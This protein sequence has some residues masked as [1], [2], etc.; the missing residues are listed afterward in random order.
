[1]TI[2]APDGAFT[3]GGGEWNFGQSVSQEVAQA[4]FMLPV[5]TPDNLLTVL[6][7]VLE[8]LPLEALRAFQP[9]FGL[10][11]DLFTN[12][13]GAVQA[14]I[15]NLIT[16]PLMATIEMLGQWLTTILQT[17][18]PWIDWAGIPDDV[19]ELLAW[20]G[21]VLHSIPFFGDFLTGAETFVEALIRNLVHW[22]THPGEI[23]DAIVAALQQLFSH[24]G[25][26]INTVISS[27]VYWLTHPGDLLTGIINAVKGALA[28]GGA[29]VQN[30][31]DTVVYWL[32]HPGDLFNAL[33]TAVQNFFTLGGDLVGTIINTLVHWM[34][35]AGAFL[36][37]LVNAVISWLKTVGIDLTGPLSF[38]QIIVDNVARFFGQTGETL[39]KWASGLV[40]A[41]NLP[42]L[43]QGLFG[44][45][46]SIFPVSM[47][48]QQE[49]VNLLNMGIFQSASTLENA[50]GWSFDSSKN[51][52]GNTGGSAKLD[53]AYQA[54]VRT[55][56]SNQ[57]IRVTAGDKMAVSAWINTLSFN[58]SNTSIQLV[59]VPF[60]GTVMK[61]E[62]L[63][64]Y[65]GPSNNVWVECTNQ[66]TPWEVPKAA[67]PADQITSIQLALRVTGD[68]TLGA[69]WFDDLT[70]W[71]TGLMQQGLVEYLISA[72]NGLL[73][74]LGV[75]VGGT[76]SSANTQDPWNFT[77]QAGANA[78][79]QANTA[80]T[81]ANTAS[82]AA[83]TAQNTAV[84][85]NSN[86]ST[87]YSTA[88]NA[89][90]TATTAYGTANNA[91]S[92]AN[93]AQT[94]ATTAQSTA[95]TAQT[96]ANNATSLANT[97]GANANTAITKA[98]GINQTLFGNTAG[99]TQILQSALPSNVTAVG[100]GVLLQRTGSAGAYTTTF[101]A[102]GVIVPW[103]FYDF[104]TGLTT[105]DITVSNVGGYTCAKVSNAGWYLV[106]VNYKLRGGGDL[107]N[108][109]YHWGLTPVI[110]RSSG[111]SVPTIPHKWG[112]TGVNVVDSYALGNNSWAADYCGGSFIV[113]MQANETVFPGY[114]WTREGS[115]SSDTI[116]QGGGT[117]GMYGTYF[118]M[119]LLNRS[120]A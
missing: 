35:N 40:S 120:L 45:I 26:L 74:G 64:A 36:T 76:P 109:A 43:I 91:S 106:E 103:G 1:M 22:I 41:F 37:A 118:A 47:V 105:P 112:P 23:W 93:T 5:P 95:G 90:S 97:A 87:A 72:W 51:R 115:A 94:T 66:N 7:L 77:L 110:Y 21:D 59:A 48:G 98:N 119:A 60:A 34:Q 4:G 113:Y 57:N 2:T 69:V 12:V 54:G 108:F 11:E 102:N 71:K 24:T 61:T 15:E 56:Y 30:V 58:G 42:A 99:G 46:F 92:T 78:K 17:L 100:S 14:I 82:S 55:L 44:S 62:V 32:T 27:L 96:T 20:F 83:A 84:N 25:E 67:I 19:N 16:R 49:K 9:V 33:R 101:N 18:F 13:G 52:T 50:G 117:T 6:Q 116:I 86:A 73:G 53:T 111:T 75:P 88:V 114:F 107:I 29:L 81:N 39:F 31:I 63:L 89:N 79:Q 80:Y 8:R 38:M 70:L 65:R 28:N 3:I 68:A 104:S 10:A 85:A